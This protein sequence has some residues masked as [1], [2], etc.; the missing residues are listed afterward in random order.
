MT[1]LRREAIGR[2]CMIRLEGCNTAPCCLAHW[3]QMGI[4]GG[5]MKSPDIIG[6]W[7]CDSCHTK[8]DSTE[9]GNRDTQLDFARG[10]FRTQAQ[11]I[12]EG[13]IT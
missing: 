11:L 5:G 6:A 7:A 3:R 2:E 10:V 8:V 4:S 1:D 12:K 9:R 13:K